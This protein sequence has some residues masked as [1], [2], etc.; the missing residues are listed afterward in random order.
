M[1]FTSLCFCYDWFCL[2]C[3]ALCDLDVFQV[4]SIISHHIMF[5]VEGYGTDDDLSN[6]MDYLQI[7]VTDA[8]YF[9]D[10]YAF[11]LH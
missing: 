9:S 6:A 2:L 4:P 8:H 5:A 7:K 1:H 11:I 3:S 10:F